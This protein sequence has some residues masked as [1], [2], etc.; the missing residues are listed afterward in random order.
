MLIHSP[1]QRLRVNRLEQ[2]LGRKLP[3]SSIKSHGVGIH[4]I[5]MRDSYQFY[6]KGELSDSADQIDW[7]AHAGAFKL[8][9]TAIIFLNFLPGYLERTGVLD[10]VEAAPT[11]VFFSG[12]SLPDKRIF[13]FRGVPV[14]KF[15]GAVKNFYYIFP[16]LPSSQASSKSSNRECSAVV[17]TLQASRPLICFI[18]LSQ[19]SGAFASS[20]LVSKLFP[21][22]S[23]SKT[24]FAV[25]N[26]STR[27]L[28]V[29]LSVFAADYFSLNVF[30]KIRDLHFGVKH[31]FVP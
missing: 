8:E 26:S 7:P 28:F 27:G 14:S 12:L 6:Y 1:R 17:L 3:D 2:G 20:A 16:D 30:C 23:H 13:L 11:G 21:Q 19:H 10:F 31:V 22:F 24:N 15:R 25:M 9:T 29:V 5:A 18:G 4:Y